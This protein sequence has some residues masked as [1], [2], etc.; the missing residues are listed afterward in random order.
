MILPRGSSIPILAQ[1]P[2]QVS[3]RSLPTRLTRPVAERG[4]LSAN[5]VVESSDPG[6]FVASAEFS[7]LGAS[8]S[9]HEA[10]DQSSFTTPPDQAPQEPANAIDT[11]QATNC[12][13]VPIVNIPAADGL[14]RRA[15][16]PLAPA[17]IAAEADGSRPT[18]RQI[19]GTDCT[20]EH[21]YATYLELAE[22]ANYVGPVPGFIAK[23]FAAAA[24]QL[25]AA[26]VQQ[27]TTENI[28]LLMLFP[29][30]VLN[31]PTG[32][33]GAAIHA[34]P[35]CTWPLARLHS[36]AASS[37]TL[38]EKIERQLEQGRVGRAAKLLAESS[39]LPCDDEVVAKLKDLHPDGL[40]NPFWRAA[41]N[42]RNTFQIDP[43]LDVMNLFTF[44]NDTG[45]GLSGWTAPLLRTALDDEGMV[46]FCTT[47]ALQIGNDSAKGRAIL[48]ATVLVP[49]AKQNGGVRPIA[50]G[51]LIYRFAARILLASLE[52]TST[53]L[54]TQLGVG[55]A[56]GVE[57]IVHAVERFHDG[58]LG[59]HRWI[60]TLDF[61]NAFNAVPRQDLAEAIGKY[62]PIAWK[63]ASWRYGQPSDAVIR[64]GD[65]LE[66][67]QVSQ[68]VAQGDPLA[69][70]FF[71]LA[72]RQTLEEI[73]RHVESCIGAQILLVA[74]LDDVCIFA[75]T[76]GALAAV[77]TFFASAPISPGLHLNLTKC[78]E[79]SAVSVREAGIALLGTFIGPVERRRAFLAAKVDE[80]IEKLQKLEHLR[81]QDRFALLSQSLQHDLRHLTR[82][83]DA[84]SIEAEWKRLDNFVTSTVLRMAE[85]SGLTETD[86]ARSLQQLPQRMGGLGLPCML[87]I[88]PYAR[89]AM[90]AGAAAVVNQ[91]ID[92]EEEAPPLIRQRELLMPVWE[93]MLADV[94]SDLTSLQVA[95]L[96]EAASPVGR[97]WLRQLP[98][99]KETVITNKTFSVSIALRLLGHSSSICSMCAGPDSFRHAESCPRSRQHPTA[100]HEAVKYAH[101]AVLQRFPRSRIIVEPV[102]SSGDSADRADLR[103]TGTA[104]LDG[105]V[106]DVDFAVHSVA[107]IAAKQSLRA[108]DHVPDPKGK[109]DKVLTIIANRLK[110]KAEEKRRRYQGRTP[111]SFVPLIISSGGLLDIEMQDAWSAWSKADKNFWSKIVSK[112]SCILIVYRAHSY[113]WIT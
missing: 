105:V 48:T 7:F 32:E 65:A 28:L 113:V 83:L 63:A 35:D 92:S 87:T 12:A 33:M 100:R 61:K 108:A 47:L 55:S 22:V 46:N 84:T 3:S 34:F 79:A 110:L 93:K 50:V 64:G 13:G 44:S 18:V 81:F 90:S 67:I 111:G 75:P 40:P 95:T 2:Q 6:D 88:L 17:S 80:E 62:N 30:V 98:V 86:H 45:T 53:L 54:P 96:L 72:I 89:Q 106:T 59:D 77:A 69:P 15:N 85:A 4:T 1:S 36:V 104:A 26:Y 41:R 49:L 23:S 78:T 76:Q 37:K 9:S 107:T 25:G 39:I 99:S 16:L 68:G 60:T 42:G 70:Y 112:I 8:D 58:E 52:T 56:F 43:E 21:A 66:R 5:C 71:S 29:K 102:V 38:K 24:G 94:T 11:T 109:T 101:R 73:K 14:P 27:P 103:I 31:R 74:Y 20:E 91:W 82:T 97:R 19:I 51:E 10:S 57:P